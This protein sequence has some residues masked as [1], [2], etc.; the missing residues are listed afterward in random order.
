MSGRWELNPVYLLPKQAYYRYTTARR[1]RILAQILKDIA[2]NI[3]VLYAASEERGKS[4]LSLRPSEDAK[5]PL[6]LTYYSRE[7]V[8]TV[9]NVPHGQLRP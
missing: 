8:Q 3:Y 4:L 2:I 9:Y 1:L 7:P 6:G 5:S